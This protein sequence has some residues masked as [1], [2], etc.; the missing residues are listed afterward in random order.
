MSRKHLAA[1][2]AAVALTVA[3]AS[4]VT[5]P[6]DAATSYTADWNTGTF[7][8]G[9]YS[10]FDTAVITFPVS[11]TNATRLQINTPTG[12]GH[13]HSGSVTLS[14]A[15]LPS[16]QS[17]WSTTLTNGAQIGMTIDVSF[18]SVA[19]VTGIRVAGTPS[20]SNTYHSWAW[21]DTVTIYG[22]VVTQ[23]SDG[24]DNEG[25]GR[26]DYPADPGCSSAQDN[27]ENSEPACMDNLDN[28]ADGKV[29]YANDYGCT[30]P[31]DTT[32]SPNPQ[33]GDGIDND[34]DGRVDMAD[35]GCSDPRTD[36]SEG[37][38]C[39]TTL[40]VTACL[41]ISTG[42]EYQRVH[43]YSYDVVNGTRHDVAG[44]VEVF[45]FRL[46]N[47]TTVNLPCV[48]LIQDGARVEPCEDAGGTYVS[49]TATLVEQT[50]YEPVVQQGAE[51]TSAAI[52]NAELVATVNDI[53]L[54]SSP[55]FT[56]C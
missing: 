11:V 44:Y 6:A 41:G 40:G 3:A 49:R 14:V 15:L 52:C 50:A 37:V 28:D 7:G 17:V 13:S 55:V 12:F 20:Q 36:N 25:D 26:V 24:V 48:T 10:D 4:V 2:L 16:G 47:N 56:L 38:S 39:T 19:Q 1:R 43:V 33:C 30:S 5:T 9:G 54:A 32:E 45:Q 53:G 34:A 27:S 42:S 35:T 46:P 51:I 23:C 21:T 8:G 22:N 31:T 18:P 29:D